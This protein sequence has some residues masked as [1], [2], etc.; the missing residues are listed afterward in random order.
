[1]QFPDTIAT[2]FTEWQMTRWRE[3]HPDAD[4]SEYNRT[5]EDHYKT[6]CLRE[7]EDAAGFVKLIEKTLLDHEATIAAAAP[8]DQAPDYDAIG[9]RLAKQMLHMRTGNTPR[10]PKIKKGP[11]HTKPKRR[12]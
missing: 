1:M 9:K 6:N 4:T 2:R 11:R 10:K 5:F 7:R 3:Q 12:R 8:E